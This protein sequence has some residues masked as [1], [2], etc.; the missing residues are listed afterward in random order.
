MTSRHRRHQTRRQVKQTSK[1][2]KQPRLTQSPSQPEIPKMPR[3]CP[4]TVVEAKATATATQVVGE[5]GEELSTSSLRNSNHPLHPTDPHPS[6]PLRPPDDKTESTCHVTRIASVGNSIPLHVTTATTTA[7][8]IMPMSAMNPHRPD[9]AAMTAASVAATAAA[10][11]PPPKRPRIDP[12]ADITDSFVRTTST[13]DSGSNSSNSTTSNNHMAKMMAMMMAE[14][15]RIGHQ[16]TGHLDHGV[17]DTIA[18][19]GTIAAPAATSVRAAAEAALILDE[20]EGAAKKPVH[21]EQWK[22]MLERL[23]AYK[24]KHGH[25]LVPKR[26]S[27]DPRLG[28]WVETQRVQVCSTNR[29]TMLCEC[30]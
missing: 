6:A 25:C 20:A 1:Q 23:M 29:S 18:A 11:E 15:E 12:A 19:S 27:E 14:S 9:N 28:T 7:G 13:T 30:R 24:A 21:N 17:M 3:P 10:V 16:P 22:E 26:Y 2:I 4:P 8:M 5:R